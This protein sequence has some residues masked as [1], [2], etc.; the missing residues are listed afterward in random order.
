MVRESVDYIEACP[1]FHPILRCPA[2]H[3]V[4]S[5]A[6]WPIS[7]WQCAAAGPRRRWQRGDEGLHGQL[8]TS[9][10]GPCAKECCIVQPY[11]LH[12]LGGYVVED[13]K[14]K[15]SGLASGVVHRGLAVG[16]SHR[17]THTPAHVRTRSLED[18]ISHSSRHLR[19]RSAAPHGY[20]CKSLTILLQ[21]HVIVQ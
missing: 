2:S 15:T 14:M 7:S 3:A 12:R 18:T 10:S 5:P 8:S 9:P 17:H 16:M 20:A 4:A 6:W 21:H 11:E 13:G 19:R 1:S